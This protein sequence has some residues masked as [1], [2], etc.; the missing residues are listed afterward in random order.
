MSRRPADRVD[1]SDTESVLRACPIFADLS[2]PSLAMLVT[3]SGVH[4]YDKQ[5]MVFQQGEPGD[6]MY[7]VARGSVQLSVREADGGEFVLA[8]I[9]PPTAF[10]DMAVVDGGPRVATA[11]TREP[12]DLVRIPRLA[13]VHLLEAEPTVGAAMLASFV[14]LVRRADEQVVDLSLRTLPSRVR[15]HLLAL[16]TQGVAAGDLG[17]DGVLALDL[18]VDQSDLARQVGGSRQQVNRILSSLEAAGAIQRRGRRIVAVRPALLTTDGTSA[19]D[20][21]T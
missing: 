20:S 8:V 18:L 21:L 19:V 7:V 16:A 17:P 11:T 10:G 5:R 14:A 12:T 13:V 6:C 3:R 9:G 4:A 2:E 15:R 1:R